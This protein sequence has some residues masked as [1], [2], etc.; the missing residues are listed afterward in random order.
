MLGVA[1]EEIWVKGQRAIWCHEPDVFVGKSHHGAWTI[2]TKFDF[3]DIGKI[4]GLLVGGTQGPWQCDNCL[5][6]CEL[7]EHVT[8]YSDEEIAT[9]V[10]Q[11]EDYG[12]DT[13]RLSL[14]EI[15]YL[16]LEAKEALAEEARDCND[17]FNQ[18]STA[19][20]HMLDMYLSRRGTDA[21]I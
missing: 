20:D 14:H 17:P 12:V 7:V 1:I 11:L 10:G 13:K 3:L 8:S 4:S 21:D 19:V 16:D 5:E 9:A 2:C 6:L 18:K 15:A